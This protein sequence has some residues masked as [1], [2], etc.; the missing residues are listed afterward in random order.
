[1]QNKFFVLLSLSLF[2][3]KGSAQSFEGEII[4]HNVFK[5]SIPNLNAEQL[6][7]LIGTEQQYFIRGG[8]YK[9]LINSQ[10]I[11]MQVYD[12]ATNRI[13]SRTP[14][15]DTLYWIDASINNDSLISYE[16]RKNAATILHYPCDAIIM[17]VRSGTMTLYYNR[18]LLL[19]GV[20]Y[21]RH[22]YENWAFYAAHTNALPLKIIIESSQLRMERTAT[23]IRPMKL[24]QDF[25]TITP[26]TPLKRRI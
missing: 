14:K 21:R 10:A 12:A 4:Y 16:I 1:M 20:R 24:G 6:C 11:N 13:Y 17:K 2:A 3:I 22:G 15:S 25:F 5:S 18:A 23:E 8:N 26:G 19:E 7:L 9:S